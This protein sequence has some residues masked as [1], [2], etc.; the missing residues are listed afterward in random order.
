MLPAP[1]GKYQLIQERK[2]KHNSFLILKTQ[3]KYLRIK[4]VYQNKINILIS[5]K[6]NQIKNN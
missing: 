1:K 5:M 2:S 4:E 6:I 3:P